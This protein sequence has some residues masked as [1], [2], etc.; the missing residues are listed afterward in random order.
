MHSHI[1]LRVDNYKGPNKEEAVHLPNTVRRVR[2]KNIAWA[3]MAAGMG[4]SKTG[5]FRAVVDEKTEFVVLRRHPGRDAP[6]LHA[7]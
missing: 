1:N 3:K 5:A 2:K 4:R 6:A 7:V